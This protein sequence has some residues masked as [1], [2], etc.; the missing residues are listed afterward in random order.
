MQY[1]YDA[2]DRIS[3]VWYNTGTDG[4]MEKVYTYAYDGAGRLYSVQDHTCDRATIYEYDITGRLIKSY[5]CEL[6]TLLNADPVNLNATRVQYDEKSR[7]AT[8]VHSFDY[9]ASSGTRAELLAY[10]YG[11]D[12]RGNLSSMIFDTAGN[13][14]LVAIGITYDD[15]N[16]VGTRTLEL[17]TAAGDMVTYQ[18]SYDYTERADA[19]QITYEAGRVSNY[20]STIGTTATEY[21]ISYD[22]NGNISGIRSGLSPYRYEYDALDQLIREDN[23]Y[24]NKTYTY[25]YDTA[26]NLVSKKTYAY[27]VYDDGDLGTPES[28]VSYTYR[29]TAWGDLLTAWNGNAITYDTIGNPTR[30]ASSSTSGYDLTW[31]GRQLMSYTGYGSNTQALTFTYNDDGIRTSKTVNGTKHEYILS[32]SQVIGEMTD[33]YQLIY[34]YDEL[35]AP[36]GLGYRLNGDPEGAYDYYFFEKNPLGD[37]IG[38]YKFDGTKVGTY[39]YD[40]WGNFVI[41]ASSGIGIWDEEILYTINPFRYRGY[42]YDVET[43]LYYLQSRYYNPQWGRFI[44]PDAW[45][46]TLATPYALTDK[47]LYAY[48]DNNPIVRVDG[49]GE[50]WNVLGGA[51][52]GVLSQFASDLITSAIEGELSFSHWSSYVGAAIGGAL[53]ML[54]PGGKVLAD[55]IGSAATTV[56]SAVCYNVESSVIG[57]NEE[58]SFEEITY[59]AIN[60]TM[61]ATAGGFLYDNS[62]MG[63][64][65]SSKKI[66][67]LNIGMDDFARGLGVAV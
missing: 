20:T 64:V 8:V 32:G 49:D 50:F 4:A 26:G 28:T 30:I 46:V 12:D 10:Q 15:M 3:E 35:G 23:P 51:F 39:S 41:T 19:D 37:V 53:G 42:F 59:T 36:L 33:T 29:N 9:P 40:A 38:L 24:L 62:K 67:K 56:T 60:N 63:S 34:F 18:V 54:V 48:C 1:I 6:S 66:P 25:E 31:Q 52:I 61:T 58:Y 7:V 45:D 5:V 11:Y 65:I 55:A 44:N 2:L 27:T 16:R 13:Q 57:R 14:E 22:A 43:G 21:I 47:N 17:E